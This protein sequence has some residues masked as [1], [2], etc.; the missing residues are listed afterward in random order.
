[1]NLIWIYNILSLIPSHH[2]R[3]LRLKDLENN[4]RTNGLVCNKI[5]E[6]ITENSIW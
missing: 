6:K 1:M 5:S 4:L 3:Y 2:I